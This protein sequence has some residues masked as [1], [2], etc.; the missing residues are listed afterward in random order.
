MAT[1]TVAA[2][3]KFNKLENCVHLQ[4][5]VVQL[6]KA[7]DIFGTIIIATEGINGTVAGTYSSIKSLVNFLRQQSGFADL[8]FKYSSTNLMPF[9]K[10]KVVIKKEIVTLRAGEIFP[11]DKTGQY[12]NAE[13][14]K[15]LLNSKDVVVIDTRNDFEVAMGTFK[16]ASNPCTTKFSEFPEYVAKNLDPTKHKKI[17]MF[18]TGGIR[19]E[20]AAAYM[21]GQGFQQVFQL[22]GGILK[23]LET[24][25]D[26]Q[27]FW[28]GECFIFDHRIAVNKQAITPVAKVE[29]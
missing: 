6:I 16:N 2:F 22:Q 18:C 29:S 5:E 21:L 10:Q 3:Y 9:K 13:Q 12:V 27:N 14:W 17:A 20:K 23:Y 4:Q 25:Q 7:E 8:E 28:Q 26:E 11:P 24:A 1:Y 19:C 15:S